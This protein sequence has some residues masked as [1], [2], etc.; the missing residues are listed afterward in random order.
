M[1]FET[2]LEN[3]VREI[4]DSWDVKFDEIDKEIA[5]LK[6]PR[7]Y[8]DPGDGRCDPTPEDKAFDV[9]FR[10]GALSPESVKTLTVG[11]DPSFGYACPPQLARE[12][13]HSLTLGNPLRPLA[14][15]YQTDKNS[16]EVLKKSASGSVVLQSSEVGE[17]LETTGLAY[18]KLTFTPATEVYLLKCSNIQ[19]EDAAFDMEQEIA[20]ELGDA[21][22][23]YECTAQAAALVANISDGTLNTYNHTHAGSTT[24]ISGDNIINLTYAVTQ[25]YLAN[26]RFIMNRTTAAYIRTLKDGSTGAYL[27]QSLLTGGDRDRLCGFPVTICDDFPAM[28]SALYPIAFGDLSKGFAICDRF[29]SFQVQ[30]LNERYAEYGITAFLARFRTISGPLDG[31]AIHWLQMSA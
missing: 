11:S 15:V 29:P 9:W 22:A 4:R 17:I 26:A 19:L 16:L 27:W 1:S 23:T 14:K 5:R 12:I 18:Q 24:V 28:T 13:Y 31:K 25:P 3:K 2:Q 6:R 7:L 20:T 30:R 8:G 10:R 21:F